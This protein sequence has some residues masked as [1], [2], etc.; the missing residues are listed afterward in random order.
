MDRMINTRKV[1]QYNVLTC[2]PST[3]E[4]EAEGSQDWG[5][6]GPCERKVGDEGPRKEGERNK[7]TMLLFN[8]N[9]NKHNGLVA[10]SMLHFFF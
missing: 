9:L 5:H 2:N 10:G 7:H 1:Y 4:T 6:L 8:F 3:E